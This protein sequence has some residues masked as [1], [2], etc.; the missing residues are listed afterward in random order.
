MQTDGGGDRSLDASSNAC[1][2]CLIDINLIDRLPRLAHPRR[3]PPPT[4]SIFR[5]NDAIPA[6]APRG[7][8]PK[9]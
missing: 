1:H 7:M 2:R 6:P 5:L 4:P 3:R 9:F 8:N